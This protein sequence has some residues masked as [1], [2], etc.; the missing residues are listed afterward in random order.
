MKSAFKKAASTKSICY[1]LSLI[2]LK[3]KLQKRKNKFA[4]L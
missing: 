2:H 1:L 3:V 4:V